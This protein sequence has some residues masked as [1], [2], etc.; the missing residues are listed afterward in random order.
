MN[1]SQAAKEGGGAGQASFVEVSISTTAGFFPTEGFNRVPSH[2]KVKVELD[3]AAKQLKITSTATGSMSS[4][5]KND[6]DPDEVPGSHPS[7]KTKIAR[8][9]A[10]WSEPGRSSR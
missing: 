6:A 3:K 1:S 9:S 7:Q 4:L 10:T 8:S 2:E 5:R